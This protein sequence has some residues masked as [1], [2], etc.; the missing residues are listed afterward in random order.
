MHSFTPSIRLIPVVCLW[1][2]T[3]LI[4]LILPGTVHAADGGTMA[5]PSCQLRLNV[6]GDSGFTYASGVADQRI[7]SAG[8][9]DVLCT[10]VRWGAT[11]LIVGAGIFSENRAGRLHNPDTKATYVADGFELRS[12]L[13]WKLAPKW[14]LE[15]LATG[16]WGSGAFTAKLPFSNGN[17]E[18]TGKSGPYGSAGASLGAFWSPIG[19]LMLGAEA[20]WDIFYGSS[21]FPGGEVHVR[22]NGPLL[23]LAIAA[24]F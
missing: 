8:S 15:A 23:R 10:P 20:G 1:A 9:L 24:P 4:S 5:T 16:R 22:G 13:S 3:V 14:H 18:V 2:G 17:F 12:G 19:N 6:G 11:G 7:S 21:D